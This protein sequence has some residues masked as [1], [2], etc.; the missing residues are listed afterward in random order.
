MEGGWL[1]GK[2]NIM[3]V[4]QTTPHIRRLGVGWVKEKILNGITVLVLGCLY[5]LICIFLDSS[6]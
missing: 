4:Q 1:Q 3:D 5:A 6:Q 2:L